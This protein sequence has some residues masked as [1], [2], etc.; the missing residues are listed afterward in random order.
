DQVNHT[1]DHDAGDEHPGEDR[2]QADQLGDEGGLGIGQRHGEQA[3]HAGGAVHRDG[4]DRVIDAQLVQRQDAHHRQQPPTPPISTAC[5]GL[6]VSGSAVIATR[7]A[8]APLRMKVRS[9]LPNIT[10]EITSA[11]S[12]PPAAARL[13]LVTAWA[14]ALASSTVAM[15]SCEPPLK[16]NQPNHS[17][18]V[19]SV[20]SGRLAPGKARITPFGPYLPRRGPRISTPASAATA[21][22]RCTTPE[23]AKSTKP[24]WSRKPPPHFQ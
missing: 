13:V 14:T 8:S 1:P 6:G 16:P 10:R 3:P 22:A 17:R 4:S 11:A 18:K 2:Q 21:P 9:D 7:P 12:R 19:P 20:A 24:I 5:S 15:L 23:P